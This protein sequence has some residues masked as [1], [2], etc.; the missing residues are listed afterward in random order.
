MKQIELEVI[1]A[2]GLHARPA[3]GF[4]KIA[5][6]FSADIKIRNLSRE[7]EFVNAKSLAKVVKIAVS[8]HQKVII[9]AAGDDEGAAIEALEEY[10]SNTTKR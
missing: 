7:S 5:K 1:D 8:Q 9:T 3:A 6:R 10:L 4:V 2:V